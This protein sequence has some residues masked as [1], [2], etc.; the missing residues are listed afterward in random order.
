ME[1]E[2]MLK[3]DGIKASDNAK[4][5]NMTT[6]EWI[7]KM[8]EK[9]DKVVIHSFGVPESILYVTGKGWVDDRRY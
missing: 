4:E 2:T 6:D 5:E 9:F 8:E 7:K 1:E 3:I